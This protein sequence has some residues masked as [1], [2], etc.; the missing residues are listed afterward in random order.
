MTALVRSTLQKSKEGTS[1]K[2]TEEPQVGRHEVRVAESLKCR[3]SVV[4]HKA[5]VGCIMTR[6]DQ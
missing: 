4:C 2:S 1:A 5:S 6:F 3:A